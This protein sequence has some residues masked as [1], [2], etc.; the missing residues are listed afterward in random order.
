MEEVPKKVLKI[1]REKEEML[2]ELKQMKVK[3]EEERLLDLEGKTRERR[4]KNDEEEW[5]NLKPQPPP[6]GMEAVGSSRS[7]KSP[8]TTSV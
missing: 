4:C 2:Q 8:G 1:T 6:G 3:G 7:E 5:V